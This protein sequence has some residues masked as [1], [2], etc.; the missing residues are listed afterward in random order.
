MNQHTR[1]PLGPAGL[2]VEAS[3]PADDA[4]SGVGDPGALE[5]YFGHGDQKPAPRS[6]FRG[7]GAIGSGEAG[8]IEA[9]RTRGYL[10]AN[11]DPL[12]LAPLPDVPELQ[13]AL[14]G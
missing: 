11:L 1:A 7:A 2:A 13:P 14:H 3:P 12:R 5:A 8:L 4:F 9:Y 6:Q 10:A